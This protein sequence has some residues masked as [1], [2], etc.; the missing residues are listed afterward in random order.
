M[1]MFEYITSFQFLCYVIFM[2]TESKRP[3]E[4]VDCD[5]SKSFA[6]FLKGILSTLLLLGIPWGQ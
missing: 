6:L 3:I 2:K 4:Q 5:L 1:K